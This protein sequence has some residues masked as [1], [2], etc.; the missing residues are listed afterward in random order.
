MRGSG[1]M[2]QV[3]RLYL[4]ELKT[5]HL[6]EPIGIDVKLPRFSW[7]L[8]SSKSDTIISWQWMLLLYM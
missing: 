7:K 6:K 8:Y 2:Y 1:K 5:E 4:T 3:N